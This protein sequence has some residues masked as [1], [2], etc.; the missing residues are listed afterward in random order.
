M[1]QYQKPSYNR[2]IPHLYRILHLK[3]TAL[4]SHFKSSL[5]HTPRSCSFSHCNSF[6]CLLTVSTVWEPVSKRDYENGKIRE[7]VI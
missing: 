4:F 3:P 7:P 2:R 6:Y 1:A 5:I